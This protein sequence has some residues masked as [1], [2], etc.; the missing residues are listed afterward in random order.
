M[1]LTETIFHKKFNKNLDKE[2]LIEK[3]TILIVVDYETVI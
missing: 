2:L 3:V 1:Q